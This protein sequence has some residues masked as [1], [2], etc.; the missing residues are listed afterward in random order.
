ML[1]LITDPQAGSDAPSQPVQAAVGDEEVLA[2]WHMPIAL[3]P[4]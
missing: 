4:V 2:V 3:P 1:A